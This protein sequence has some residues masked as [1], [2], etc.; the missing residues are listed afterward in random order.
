MIELTR[1][2]WLGKGL[3]GAILFGFGGILLD[4]WM[5]ASRFS[6]AHWMQLVSLDNLP[7]DGTYPFTE[8]KVA[9]VLDRG[10][11]AAISLEC[12]HLG[13]L[14]NTDDEGFFCPCHGSEFGPKGE[15]YSG[16]APRPLPWHALKV[17][18]N[19][20]WLHSGTKS[21]P[22]LWVSVQAASARMS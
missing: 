19:Q 20:V 11:I 1:R 18:N 12:T 8:H 5:S 3:T 22:P 14:V 16:P 13:C 2:E 9:L 15:V 21:N 4:V 10:H 17:M 7:G 6:S